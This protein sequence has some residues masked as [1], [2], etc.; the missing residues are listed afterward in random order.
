MKMHPG[1]FPQQTQKIFSA[2][3]M[4][5]RLVNSTYNVREL[6]LRLTR[7]LCQF[8][9]ADSGT[10][11]IL[12]TAKRRIAMIAI[13]DNKINIFLDRKEQMRQITAKELRVTQGYAL[14]ELRFIGLPLVADDIIGAIFV[15]R[16]SRSQPFS[17]FDKAMLAVFAEQAV[18]AIKNLQLYEQQQQT[19]LSSIKLIDKLLNK[20][21]FR[22]AGR[23]P[24]Y[25]EVVRRLGEKLGV[26]QEGLKCL[27]YAS[28]LHDAGAI[29]I[30]YEILSKRSQL[31]ADEFKLIRDLPTKSAELIKPVDFLKP[32]LPIVLYHRERYDGTGYPLGLK[33]EQIPIGARIIS[34]VEAF[35]VMLRGRPYK[36]S[37][38]PF[39]AIDELRQNSG[40]QFDPRVVE[41]FCSLF[42][43]K[44]FRKCLSKL[45]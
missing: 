8:I 31:T 12:D 36:E 26:G 34:V 23:S 5:Y 25:F 39:Q 6:I 30:P 21:R 41:A 18:T 29:D 45:K 32:I 9:K 35:E 44:K 16:P 13:F 2:V 33:K 11:F 7:L 28:M 10:V 17:A 22:L 37:L 20:Q 40:T 4:V 15:K 24:A 38:T 1:K 14:Q 43:E 42:K 19:I 3:H 27:Y